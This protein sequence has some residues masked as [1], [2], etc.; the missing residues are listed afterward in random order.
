M[1]ESVDPHAIVVSVKQILVSIDRSGYKEKITGYAISLSK[2]W[3]ADLTAIH[4]IEPTYA[5]S[6]DGGEAESKEQARDK[7]AR[8]QAEQLLNE[9]DILA[10][11]EGMNIK[12][13]AVRPSDLLAKKEGMNIKKEA[14]KK[15]DIVGKAIIDYAKENGIDIIVIGTKGMTAVEEYF[16]GSVANKV[17]HHAHCPVFAI[18]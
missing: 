9:I 8:R 6:A 11:K 4:V 5:L 13:E 10:K 17:I 7:E 18:R 2:A 14:L 3:G 1:K 15:S 16:F 12:K